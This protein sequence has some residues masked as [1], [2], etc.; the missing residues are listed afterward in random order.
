MKT[1]M[2]AALAAAALTCA[3]T[4]PLAAQETPTAKI[5]RVQMKEQKEHHPEIAAAMNHLREAK[6]NLEHAAHD[7]GGHRANALKHVNEALEE[8]RLALEYD[9]K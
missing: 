1:K 6:A 2:C 4:L 5:K 3:M 9:K 7:F 8:C